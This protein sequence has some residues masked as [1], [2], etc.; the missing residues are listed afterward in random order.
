[1]EVI[2]A[3]LSSSQE[4]L[5]IDHLARDTNNRICKVIE[6]LGQRCVIATWKDFQFTE[7][8]V[9]ITS[10]R[11]RGKGGFTLVNFDPPVIP[12]YV[13]FYCTSSSQRPLILDADSRLQFQTLKDLGILS[14]ESWYHRLCYSL[15]TAMAERGVPVNYNSDAHQW[16]VKTTL[17]LRCREY[18]S[19]SG[20]RIPRPPTELVNIPGDALKMLSFL[21]AHSCCILKPEHGTRAEGLLIIESKSQVWGLNQPDGGYVLQELVPSP[22]LMNRR[23]FDVRAYLSISNLEEMSI[24]IPNLMIVR[25][26]VE[27]YSARNLASEVCSASYSKRLGSEP[28]VYSLESLLN[29][30]EFDKID[31]H[32][33]KESA[34][35]TL[36]E[37]INAVA[38]RAGKQQAYPNLMIWGID[39]EVQNTKDGPQAI[40]IEANTFPLLYWNELSIDRAMDAV[41]SEFFN[42]IHRSKRS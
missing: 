4:Y 8:D 33:I 41:L 36:K 34:T 25:C 40:L 2:I 26:A 22:A 14:K 5:H 28:S 37:F 23:K 19:S 20:R 13:F 11:I 38:W 6:S 39:L 18:E 7:H 29:S 24:S 32:A 3:L 27:P 42:A 35:E 9:L 31:W 15:L 16:R 12:D 10:G 1:M 17:E 30:K 21:E